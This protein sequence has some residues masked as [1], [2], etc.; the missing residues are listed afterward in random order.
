MTV[1]IAFPR[2]IIVLLLLLATLLARA[3]FDRRYAAWDALPNQH[4]VL[5]SNGNASQ[6]NYAGFQT[7]QAALKR[8][9]DSLSAVGEA[10]YRRWSK[11]QQ[12]AFLINAYNA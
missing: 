2:W 12:L 1:K 5:I 11:S 10:D 6:M 8:Y 9:L 4:V 3:V 7:D